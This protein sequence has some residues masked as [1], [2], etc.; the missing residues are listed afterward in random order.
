MS[1]LINITENEGKKAVSAKELYLGLGLLKQNWTRWYKVN[2]QENDFFLENEN[3]V[4]VPLKEEG[5]ETMDFAISIEFAKHIAMMAR[6][7][8]SH[9]Y[10]NYFLDCEKQVKAKP[11]SIEDL[12][13]MQAQSMKDIRQQLNQVNHA[14]LVAQADTN[15]VKDNMQSLRDVMA[16]NHTA[17]RTEVTNLLNKIAKERGGTA[18]AYADIRTES[19]KLLDERAG[20]S[21]SIRLTNRKRKVLEETGSK[22]KA[23]KVSKMDVIADDKRLTEVYLIIVKEM[24]FRYK[25]A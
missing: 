9:E 4:G 22:S 23:D 8:K 3:W 24:A 11:Q 18:E 7:E 14:V 5:N 15:E 21:L 16:I 25:V 19:Y 13:I 12:I 6:T 2:I 10:R 20:A 1:S 17:W